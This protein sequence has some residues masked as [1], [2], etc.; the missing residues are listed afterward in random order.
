MLNYD[1]LKIKDSE[2]LTQEKWNGLV[3]KIEERDQE[4]LDVLTI[5]NGNVGIGTNMPERALHIRG[6]G[7]FDDDLIIESNGIEHS[8][9]LIFNKSQT[10]KA[11]AK[12]NDLLGLVAFR[13]YDGNAYQN[14]AYI[15]AHAITNF[16]ESINGELR[17]YTTINGRSK[18]RL[19]ITSSGHIRIQSEYG[20][21]DV[22]AKNGTWSHF[23]TDREK[24]YFDKEIRVD[25]GKI[26]SY[27]EHLQLCTKGETKLTVLTNG[28]VGVGIRSPKEA[29]Q[30]GNK[31]TFHNGGSKII[32]LNTYW[33]TKDKN[34]KYLLDGH[35]SQIAFHNNGGISLRVAGTKEGSENSAID[36]NSAINIKNDGNVGIGDSTPSSKLEVNGI[37]RS[38]IYESRASKHKGAIIRGRNGH[39][40]SF[41]WVE[42]RGTY[43]I[44]I[45]VDD[46]FVKAIQAWGE[47]REGHDKSRT[48][49]KTDTI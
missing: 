38:T 20:W 26:G 41:A 49:R 18:E 8:G 4:I 21:V 45:Y 1:E 32:G 11:P 39:K 30:I 7:L 36:Y 37:T 2:I 28:N 12:A 40:L 23:Y 24:Y 3:T 16:D 10:D 42:D 15:A 5:S 46:T 34:H 13:G 35:A 22:G 6:T 47:I 19:K 27:N 29:M 48:G 31:W 17:I 9:A 43:W 33:D 44:R 25:S 14:G